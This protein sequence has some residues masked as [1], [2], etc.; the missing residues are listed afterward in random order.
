MYIIIALAKLAARFG[1]G[2]VVL[3]HLIGQGQSND[4]EMQQCA[5][6]MLKVLGHM[7]VCEKMLT[8]IAKS[9]TQVE[10]NPLQIIEAPQTP[11]QAKPVVDLLLLVLDDTSSTDSSVRRGGGDLLGDSLPGPQMP[12]QT[13]LPKVQVSVRSAPGPAEL[14]RTGEVICLGQTKANPV[15]PVNPSQVALRLFFFSTGQPMNEF[16]AE[17]HIAPNWK[18]TVQPADGQVLMPVDGKPVSQ[19]LYLMS[20]TKAQL[21]LQV[22]MEI[23]I[24]RTA[25]VWDGNDSSTSHLELNS[26]KI[27]LPFLM[28]QFWW[29]LSCRVSLKMSVIAETKVF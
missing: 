23:S 3:M 1:K 18:M 29:G 7:D 17:Y 4:L 22:K 25:V 9:S 15:N 24:W 8:P 10:Q 2:E 12:L 14:F 5:G 19:I 27:I 26:L 21:Q 16:V 11:V 20:P 28:T 13:P 6:E